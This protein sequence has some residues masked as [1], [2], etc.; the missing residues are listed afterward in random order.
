MY[1]TGW[2]QS[3]SNVIIFLAGNHQGEFLWPQ[4]SPVLDHPR[5]AAGKIR[6]RYSYEA[7]SSDI[8]TNS[9]LA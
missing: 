7:P 9:N 3:N 6:R 5:F 2:K 4:S 1:T 8:V